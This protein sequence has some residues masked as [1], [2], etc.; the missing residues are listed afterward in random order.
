MQFNTASN[1]TAVGFQAGRNNTTGTNN[2]LLG[3]GTVTGNFNDSIIIGRDATAI[4]S[5]QFVVGSA[6]YPAGA[7]TAEV[8]AS[9][10]VWNVRINGTAAKILLA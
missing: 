10:Q 2:T 1:N 7:I 3:Y 5:N 9:T 4:A 8:N 6:A